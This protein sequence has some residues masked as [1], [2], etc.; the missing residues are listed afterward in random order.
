VP[1]IS[2]C[3]FITDL[4]L[5]TARPDCYWCGDSIYSV[6]MCLTTPPV[7]C[8]ALAA[9]LVP[10]LCQSVTCPSYTPYTV[11][12]LTLKYLTDRHECLLMLFYY[13][14]FF[15]LLFLLLFLF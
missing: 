8:S 6:G 12:A 9:F 4:T 11:N 1:A 15:F 14:L 10:Q 5:C 13:C 2:S 7:P 3:D